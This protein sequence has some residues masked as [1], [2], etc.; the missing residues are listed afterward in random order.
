VNNVARSSPLAAP[1]RLVYALPMGRIG[2]GR[3]AVVVA[4]GF[5][6]ILAWGSSFYLPAVL[7]PAIVADTGWPLDWIIG[8]ASTGL[9]VAALVSPRVGRLIAAR[10]G[11]PVLVTGSALFAAGLAALAAAPSLPLYLLAWAVLGL[12]M[13]CGLYDAAFAALGRLYGAAA[14]GPMTSLTLFGGFASTV[15]WPLSAL[16]LETVGWRGTCLVYAGLHL[17]LALPLQWIVLGRA[18]P[19]PDTPAPVASVSPDGVPAAIAHERLILVLLGLAL[20]I[21]AG[22]GA[23]VVVH[24]LIFL[25]AR[26]VEFAVAVGLGTLFGPA[27]VGARVVE[28]LFGTH[29]HPIWTL[30]AAVLL[31]AIGL[32]LLIAS[33]AFAVAIAL[34]AAGYGITWVARG[35]LP[36]ALFGPRRFPV[37]IGRLALP[38]LIAQALAP[39]LGAMLITRYGADVTIWVLLACAGANM[40]IVAALSF[41]CR[42]SKR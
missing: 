35:T 11:R 2:L 22:I 26:G 6:Q 20:S 7:A 13:G 41:F 1:R 32:A 37:L 21:A 5:V 9:L 28:R 29:Y 8:G 36:L 14:R 42:L 10:G 39:A 25:Q 33:P 15:C 24:L 30:I 18:V 23:I 27:Q 40:A 16:L 38:S 12:G 4:L 19:D 17:G 31:M 3:S 34:Y